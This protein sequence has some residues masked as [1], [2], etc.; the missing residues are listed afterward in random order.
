MNSTLD[1]CTSD[2]DIFY[3]TLFL[4]RMICIYILEQFIQH[5]QL[6]ASHYKAVHTSDVLRLFLVYKF[7]GF[8]LDLDYVVI[9][10]LSHYNNMIVEEG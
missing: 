3:E 2:E 10:D 7:G 5:G 8:Y 9:R 4:F 1:V 6:N